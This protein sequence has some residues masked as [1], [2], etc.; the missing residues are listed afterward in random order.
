[1]LIGEYKSKL[2]AK[3]RLAFPK[4]FREEMGDKLVVT[5]GYENSLIVV[6]V[7]GWKALAEGTEDKPF[8]FGS[9]RET[10]RFLLGGAS[11]V[12]LDEQGRFIVPPYLREY[13]NL[14]E[15][16]VFLGLNKYVEVWDKKHWEEHQQYLSDH[17]GEIAE[18]LGQID[19][20]TKND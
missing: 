6:P 11:E 10:S 18:K 8:L 13:A 2:S 5:K 4:R 12:E 17:I 19:L 3:G 9:A 20:K 14:G 7:D 16:V 15:E 1:M